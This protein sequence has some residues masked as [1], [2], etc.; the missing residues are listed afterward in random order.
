MVTR[1][2][3]TPTHL[4]WV[5]CLR[6]PQRF[7][8]EGRQ[9][10]LHSPCVGDGRHLERRDRVTMVV[11]QWQSMAINDNQWKSVSAAG[12]GDF[13]HGKWAAR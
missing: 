10:I 6:Q 4:F 1:G 13:S 3:T 9:A 5:S 11:N 7:G 8:G 12:G 2:K